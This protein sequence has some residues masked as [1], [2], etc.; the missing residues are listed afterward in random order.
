ME[1]LKIDM[2]PNQMAI[3]ILLKNSLAIKMSEGII[4]F[5]F[6][7]GAGEGGGCLTTCV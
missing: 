1:N 6:W 3:F 7:W 4:I 5:F 2:I